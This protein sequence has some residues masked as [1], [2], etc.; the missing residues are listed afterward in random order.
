[1]S[2]ERARTAAP[3]A[4][5]DR[6]PGDEG[7]T[8][9]E[10]IVAIVIIG[11]VMAAAAPFMVRT[12]SVSNQQRTRQQAV[13]ILNDGLERVRALDPT[14]LLSGRGP[15]EVLQQWNA[16][17]SQVKAFNFPFD[18]AAPPTTLPAGSTLGVA[19]PLP[20]R[21]VPV[22]IGKATFNQNF[23]VGYC[24]QQKITSSITT[25]GDCG[26]Q[27]AKNT[28]PF[29]WVVVS[30]TW[31]QGTVVGSTL[32]SNGEDPVF[33]IN[34]AAPSIIDLDP[35][36]SY[37]A[38]ATSLQMTA[39]GG[40][41]PLT[42]S[43]TGLPTGMTI[44]ADTGLI[45]GTPTTAGSYSV[46]V[47]VL[48]KDKRA[49]T[50]AFAWTIVQPLALTSPGD[51]TSRTGTALTLAV[52]ATGG[53]TPLAWKATGL[54]AGLSLNATTGVITGTPTTAATTTTQITVTDS[55]TPTPQ[56]KTVS[57]SWR[58]LTPVT[59]ANPGTQAGT[60]G[61]IV[62]YNLQNAASGGLK[63][64]TWTATNLPDGTSIN[65]STGAVSG[66]LI[67]GSR[68][69][70]TVTVTDAA[71]GTAT[72]D[73][74]VLVTQNSSLDLRITSPS[75]TGPPDQSTTQNA[76]V[77]LN[78]AAAPS[79]TYTWSATNLP[80]GLSINTSTGAITGKP[81]TKGAWTVKLTV[82]S[83]TTAANLM[84]VWTVK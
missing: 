30:V 51:Q 5:G 26:A 42:W 74:I 43:A 17:P 46:T 73:V 81:T 19:A 21:P 12:L 54:P 40:R 68:Y 24:W 34:T 67:R 16:A 59:L 64:Y 80:P 61:T 53:I 14:A 15:V 13:Q 27:S 77:T 39:T 55:G 76:A 2:H 10:V 38:T 75:P 22:T 9:V 32:V 1:M 72:M 63:P 41:L 3:R 44:A 62:T 6:A 11:T 79:G 52:T 31:T 70:T 48:D 28:V 83:S 25:T 7:Y 36:S 20:T 69:I 29:F 78:P 8:L 18:T 71:G 57:F 66:Q 35:Q 84:F 60:N 58:V 65:G 45:S 50:S 33:N 23:Y 49:D 56:T 47:K 37:I 4:R 82:K